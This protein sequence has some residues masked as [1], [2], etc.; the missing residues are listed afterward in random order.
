[1]VVVLVLLA[2]VE[3]V[4]LVVVVPALDTR[5]MPASRKQMNTLFIYYFILFLILIV[6]TYI[7]YL[8]TI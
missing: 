8:I 6:K 2:L 1:M 5:T 4:V 3:F 7:G